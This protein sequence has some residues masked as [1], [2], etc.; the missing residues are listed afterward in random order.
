MSY[1]IVRSHDVLCHSHDTEFGVGN[2]L[3]V[4]LPSV[5]VSRQVV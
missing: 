2:T 4:V 5:V 3:Y 1:I